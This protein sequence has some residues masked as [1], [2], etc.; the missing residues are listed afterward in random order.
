MKVGNST[1]TAVA[2]EAEVLTTSAGVGAFENLIIDFTGKLDLTKSYDQISIYGDYGNSAASTFCFDTIALASAPPPPNSS[3]SYLYNETI[4][5]DPMFGAPLTVGGSS[6]NNNE[7]TTYDSTAVAAAEGTHSV[8]FNVPTGNG[9]GGGF[10]KFG[11]SVD[12]SAYT[13]VTF[14]LNVAALSD[15]NF[16]GFE[17][18]LEE[19]ATVTGKDSHGTVPAGNSLNIHDYAATAV[20]NGDWTSYTIP[21]ADFTKAAGKGWDNV[22]IALTDIATIGFWNPNDGAGVTGTYYVDNIFFTK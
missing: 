22:I 2:A 7:V 6:Q 20:V 5:N 4:G 17:A 11:N 15:K 21:L 18:K 13:S 14:S 3:K 12:L 10:I 9:Y 19:V 16:T 1:D 8:A